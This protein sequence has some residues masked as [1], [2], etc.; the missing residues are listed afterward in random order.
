VHRLGRVVMALMSFMLAA[1]ASELVLRVAGYQ[2]SPV[3]IGG[4]VTGDWRDEHAFHDRNLVYDPVLIWR[5]VSGQFSP[6]NPQGFRGVPVDT[7]KPPGTLRIVAL[8]DSN[9][10]GWDVDEGANWPSQL[11]AL[12]A[13]SHPGTEVINAGV[14]GYSSFQGVRRF[15]EM[16][17]FAPDIVLISFGA[18]DAHQVRVPDAAYVRRHDRMERLTRATQRLRL[19][20]LAVAVADRVDT[21]SGAG[22]ALEPRVS[23]DDYAAHLREMV[24]VGQQRGIQLVLLTRPFTGRSADPASWKTHA[25]AYNAVVGAVA[26]EENVLAIDLHAH[27]QDHPEYF[28]DE[29]HFG[30]EGHRVAAELIYAQLVRRI[31]Q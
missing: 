5:P 13:T 29:S 16:L 4:D 3:Q 23:L 7:V 8:G 21:A 15:H 24:R 11:Q 27:V 30:V 25:P 17:A 9:T 18:N 14:W 19:A 20:Q 12:F 22:G 2:Y 26:G 31:Q 1:A 6:F 28:D 10:F